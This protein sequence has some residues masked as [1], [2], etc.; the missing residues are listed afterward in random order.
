VRCRGLSLTALGFLLA[1][2]CQPEGDGVIETVFDPCVSSILTVEPRADEAQRAS[3]VDAARAWAVRADARLTVASVGDATDPGAPRLP[4]RFEPAAN[5]FFGFYDDEV[6]VV[7]IN[8]SLEPAGARTATVAHEL[9]HAFGLFHVDP[10][11]RASVMNAG[12]QEQLPTEQDVK[13]LRSL[14]G[15]CGAAR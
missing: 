2:G 1:T 15:D 3:V 4:I 10:A 13:Q 5:L 14:W 12:N 6:G 11:E 8:D 7:F 9:G